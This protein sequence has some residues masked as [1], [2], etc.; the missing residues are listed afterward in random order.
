MN[1]NQVFE[2]HGVFMDGERTCTSKINDTKP[3]YNIKYLAYTIKLGAGSI[4]HQIANI[5][6]IIGSPVVR[7]NN[8]QAFNSV[9]KFFFFH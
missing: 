3:I 5:Y 8:R 7:V 9:W 6:K 2:F 4:I 1:R